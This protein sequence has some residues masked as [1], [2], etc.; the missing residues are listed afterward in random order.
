MNA[1]HF[2]IK[3]AE[4]PPWMV[5]MKF[6]ELPDR[7][8]NCAAEKMERQFKNREITEPGEMLHVFA[9]RMMMA[10]NGIRDQKLNE[11][12]TECINYIDDLLAAER[13][14]P[15]SPQG[16]LHNGSYESH[17]GYVYW[18]SK[19]IT[20]YFVRVRQH[21]VEASNEA[22][23]QQFPKFAAQLLKYVRTNGQK[24]LEHVCQDGQYARIPVL[25]HIKPEKFVAAWF[26]SPIENWRFIS[27]AL[28]SRYELGALDRELA[29][30]RDWILKVLDLVEDAADKAEGFRAFRMQRLIHPN[31]RALGEKKADT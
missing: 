8:V 6:E 14:P 5:V 17:A 2:F 12:T 25:A 15:A 26:D 13:L 10:E 28:T 1:S 11:V 31:L 21:L 24:F 9:L 16:R 20:D 30:E 27:L 19:E 7:D 22:F 29:K 18:V 3:P 4:V 23:K